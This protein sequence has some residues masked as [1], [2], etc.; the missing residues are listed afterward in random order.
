[1]LLGIRIKNYSLF[2]DDRA[3]ALLEDYLSGGVNNGAAMSAGLP[4]IIPMSSLNAVIGR[5]QS[6]KSTF[7]DCL[8]FISDAVSKGCVEASVIRG[9]SGFS[10]LISQGADSMSFEL[11]FFMSN[12]HNPALP[13]EFYVS[14][15]FSLRPDGNGKPSFIS[16]NVR[17][18][19]RP[20]HKDSYKTVL[21][22]E[23]GTGRVYFSDIAMEASLSDS[24]HSALRTYGNILQ[25]PVLN[26]LLD[27]MTKWFFCRFSV[28]KAENGMKQKVAPGAH[29]HLNSDG[30]NMKNVLDYLSKENPKQYRRLMDRLSEKIPKV[31]RVM[32]KLP[33][34]FRSSPNRL[35]LYLLLLH[36]PVPR[37]LICIET[38]DLELYHDMVDVLSAEFRDYS[39]RNPYSQIIFSTHNP[40]ILEAMAPN[41][42]WIFK[43]S[44]EEEPDSVDIRC[45]GADPVVSE[46]YEQGV[47]MGAMWYSGHFDD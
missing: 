7:F 27:E 25:C 40:Y 24:R 20:E 3:G 13:D 26:A 17:Y 45:A 5:N 39:I 30:S 47:G 33:D 43:R 34:D 9:R 32:D 21:S 10:R 6:G 35:F 23:N 37:P 8:S 14:Y 18:T 36:D 42:V 31:G 15:S 16:E 44:D 22:V 29:K 12:G 46:M 4:A 19:T 38:P 11:L 2:L 41:E 28:S 1:M